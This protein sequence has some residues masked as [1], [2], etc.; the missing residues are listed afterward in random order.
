MNNYSVR[1]L[2]FRICWRSVEGTEVRV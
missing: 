2:Y 1:C